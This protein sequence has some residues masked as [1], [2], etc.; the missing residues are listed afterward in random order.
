MFQTSFKYKGEFLK[1][2]ISVY[3]YLL[4]FAIKLILFAFLKNKDY[5]MLHANVYTTLK[6]N[7]FFLN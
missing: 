1:F 2:F 4:R 5:K 6:F 3:F 7:L